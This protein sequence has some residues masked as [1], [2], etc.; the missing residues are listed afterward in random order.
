VEPHERPARKQ[1]IVGWV[2]RSLVGRVQKGV[3]DPC[4]KLG[5]LLPQFRDL[6]LPAHDDAFEHIMA[7]AT[8]H[9]N[10][11]FQHAIFAPTHVP[12]GVHV[13]T[14][15]FFFR[16]AFRT[17]MY[18]A[19]A[20]D[21]YSSMEKI[22]GGC[23]ISIL[24]MRVRS[25]IPLGLVIQIFFLLQFVGKIRILIVHFV[26]LVIPEVFHQLCRRVAHL[27]GNREVSECLDVFERGKDCVV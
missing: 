7:L 24:P 9:A 3:H 27:H 17:T 22:G 10:G 15:E 23:R 4:V 19:G 13:V 14:S 26:A 2:E 21:T 12:F 25:A 18:A 5:I 16:V 6:A 8:E 20:S 1:L 11:T